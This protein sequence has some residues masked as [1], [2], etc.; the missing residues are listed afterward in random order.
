MNPRLDGMKNCAVQVRLQ[1]PPGWRFIIEEVTWHGY[2][3]LP[4]DVRA[5]FFSSFEISSVDLQVVSVPTLQVNGSDARNGQIVT[6]RLGVVNELASLCTGRGS[7]DRNVTDMIT[8]RDRWALTG[9]K[10]GVMVEDWMGG[11]G[12]RVA[13][14][15]Q[16]GLRWVGCR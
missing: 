5:S 6:E 4:S 11:E 14:I 10:T 7:E 15:Q 16:I 2:F 13:L 12:E 8:V 9:L 1:Y 3:T